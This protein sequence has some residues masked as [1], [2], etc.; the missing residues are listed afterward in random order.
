MIER[1]ADALA[2]ARRPPEGRGL[3]AVFEGIDGAGKTTAC[4]ALCAR[5]AE[6]SVDFVLVN[7]LNHGFRD[8]LLS[9]A[10][11]YAGRIVLRASAASVPP[12][13][14]TLA[15]ADALR[16]TLLYEGAVRPA[17][18][19]GQLVIADS[20]AVKRVVKNALE[21]ARVRPDEEGVEQWLAALFAPA[22]RE[23]ACL[24]LNPPVELAA[25]RKAGEATPWEVG[26]D[27][28]DR[29]EHAAFVAYQGRVG[30]AL[31]A[32]ADRL[33]WRRLDVTA[34]ATPDAVAAAA[35]TVLAADPR[36]PS[37]LEA[38]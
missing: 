8:P 2:A 31:D 29:D 10:T 19:R 14:L 4:S 15:A 11:D 17:L 1:L 22:L 30:S 9:E 25:A 18:E 34:G 24:F 37:P 32:L 3:F 27:A 35:L 38:A 13:P 7:T 16:Y 12:V 28:G 33:G 5:L 36:S 6:A 20:W 23:H 21:L 26:L